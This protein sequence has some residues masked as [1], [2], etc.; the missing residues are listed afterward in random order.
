MALTPCAAPRLSL[1]TACL[2][3]GV[4]GIGTGFEAVLQY[5]VSEGHDEVTGHFMVGGGTG[6]HGQFQLQIDV[7][8]PPS[9]RRAC[10][11]TSTRRAPGTAARSIV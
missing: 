6:E 3:V 9:R 5:R 2:T 10:S 7:S 8:V 11:S 1:R 4:G